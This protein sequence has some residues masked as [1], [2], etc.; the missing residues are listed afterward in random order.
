MLFAILQTC[1]TTAQFK[2]PYITS[3]PQHEYSCLYS[4]LYITFQINSIRY[5]WWNLFYYSLQNL[6][7]MMGVMLLKHYATETFQDLSYWLRVLLLSWHQIQLHF[8][9]HL[10]ICCTEI[11]ELKQ[12]CICCAPGCHYIPH[13]YCIH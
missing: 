10:F 5:F 2:L 4:C 1:I 3:I 12:F 7:W 9:T 6:Q 13:V 11:C 8:L